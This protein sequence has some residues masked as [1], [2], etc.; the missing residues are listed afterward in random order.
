MALALSI[1]FWNYDRT[2]PIADGRV[3]VEGCEPRCVV[4]RPQELFPRA[5][6]NTEF[7]VAEL[8]L[9]RYLAA[10]ARGSSAYA[11]IPV[12]PSRS[13]RHASIYVRTDSGIARPQDLVGRTLGL[14]NYDD[15]AAV[16]ARGMLRDDYGLGTS[17][18]TWC[19]GDMEAGQA[20]RVAL[21]ALP[22]RIR[23]SCAPQG[24]TLDAL[25]AEGAIDGV[26]S[27]APPPCFRGGHPRIARLF[28]DWRRAE[29]D[30]FSRTGLFPI[31]HVIGVRTTLLESE[32]GLARSLYDAFCRAKDLA[33]AE[34]EILQAPKV[35]LP[36]VAAELEESRALLGRD[37]WPY[38]VAANRKVVATQIRYST[39][40]GLL[41]GPLEVDGL[42][43]PGLR[44]T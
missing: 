20:P 43:V 23:M 18:I 39:E 5:F 4:L 13:F 1:A 33:V 28:P 38:G 11:A 22:E 26:I 42:F 6:G 10:C 32:P 3:P 17:D 29:R 31:M 27:I 2:L 41:S 15:T 34:L 7:D 25:L 40:D 30:W 37:F 8:S 35:T 24:K 9:N 19:I 21:P 14:N 12:F 36:W 44:D 16:V